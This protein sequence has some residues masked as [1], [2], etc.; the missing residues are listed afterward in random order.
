M[1]PGR[2]ATGARALLGSSYG[3]EWREECSS[4]EVLLLGDDDFGSAVGAK[5]RGHGH[6]LQRAP[7]RRHVGDALPRHQVAIVAPAPSE[8]GL[9]VA[10]GLRE[11]KRDLRVILAVAEPTVALEEEAATR[12][13]L[14][15]RQ[16]SENP[17]YFHSLVHEILAPEPDTEPAALRGVP[18]GR[19]T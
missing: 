1:P 4:V 5:L 19:L 6:P 10:D 12:P 14:R 15:V 17:D 13:Y 18:R 2:G 9:A 11:S 3:M 16:R 7:R 8:D